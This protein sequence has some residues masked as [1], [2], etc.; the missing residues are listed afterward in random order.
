MTSVQKK[1]GNTATVVAPIAI[2]RMEEAGSLAAKQFES[3]GRVDLAGKEW[4]KLGD[5]KNVRRCADA[6]ETQEYL[7]NAAEKW[8][9]MLGLDNS[10]RVKWLV[11]AAELW[12]A[13]G[14]RGRTEACAKM[15]NANGWAEDEA[16][17]IKMLK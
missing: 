15:S 14:E 5:L 12:L 1:G 3:V 10:A 7:D 17:I 11:T 4:L 13:V 6:C 9:H 2:L 16:M 8:L